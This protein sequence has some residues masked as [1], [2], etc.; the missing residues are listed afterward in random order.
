MYTLITQNSKKYFTI[1]G[2]V[3]LSILIILGLLEIKNK[4]FTQT[5]LSK[6]R[7]IQMS[8]EGK[9]S[10]APDIANLS[11]AVVAN[12]QSA[13]KV[14]LDNDKKMKSVIDYIKQNGVEAKDIQTSGY[15]LY[16]QYDYNKPDINPPP[17]TSYT[18]SQNVDVKIRDLNKVSGIV[19]GLT[20]KGVNQINNIS[21]SINDPDGL[22]SE[23]RSMAIEKSKQ[24]AKELAQTLDIKLGKVINFSE[25]SSSTPYP[26]PYYAEGRG[27]EGS[28]VQPGSQD[29]TVNVTLTFSI[30]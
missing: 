18:L 8:A 28:P 2:L 1:G 24:K 19:G 6:A 17:I 7:S 30:K 26:L 21:Y 27:G 5:D 23:A 16:P 29:I 3:L 10:A 20:G 13:E 11:F 22:K 4:I 15:N 12:G 9:V 25:D 14:Q